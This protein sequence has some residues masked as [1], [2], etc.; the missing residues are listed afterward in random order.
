[1]VDFAATCAGKGSVDVASPLHMIR[2]HIAPSPF[3][4]L[5]H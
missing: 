5:L 3:F 4:T 2:I 1:M